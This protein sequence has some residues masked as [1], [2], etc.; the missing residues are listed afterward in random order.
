MSHIFFCSILFFTLSFLSGCGDD[1]SSSNTSDASCSDF[2]GIW[3]ISSRDTI[4][5]S[6][7]NSSVHANNATYSLSA[8]CAGSV[9][10]AV[11]SNDTVKQG[12]RYRSLSIELSSK[13]TGYMKDSTVVVF[14]GSSSTDYQQ[15]QVYKK[16]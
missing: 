5:I 14:S 12:V 16:P 9:L 4:A 1:S 6:S 15:K 10:R 7:D 2:P 3:V 8:S 13:T 11:Y